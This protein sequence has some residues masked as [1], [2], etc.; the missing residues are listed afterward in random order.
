MDESGFKQLLSAIQA[1]LRAGRFPDA[2]S[3][4]RRAIALR[5]E[6]GA[7]CMNLAAALGAQGKLVEALDWNER[8]IR[9]RPTDPGARFNH[10]KTLFDLGRF[11][12]AS[13][14][15]E[16]SLRLS[17]GNR[18]AMR[19]LGVCRHLTHRDAEAVEI[20][21][22]VVA[23]GDSDPAAHAYLGQAMR[24]LGRFD[25]AFD[26]HRLAVERSP[27]DARLRH[28]LGL[29]LLLHGQWPEGWR[30]A[31]ARWETPEMQ[32]IRQKMPPLMWDG[33]SLRGK[34]IYLQP[35]QGLGD[36]IQFIRYAERI[37][38]RGGRVVAGCDPAL[39]DL[40]S[41]VPGVSEAVHIVDRPPVCDCWIGLMSLPFVFDTQPETA[42]A[43]VPY[44]FPEPARVAKWS[45]RIGD[46]TQLRVGIAWAGSPKHLRDFYRS[47]TLEAI[48]PLAEIANL[49][50]FSLQKDQSCAGTNLTDLATD[51][52]TL[53]DTAAAIANLDLVISVDTAV[54]HLAGAMGKPVWLLLGYSPDWRWM[55]DRPDSPWYP[56][57]RI[58]RQSKLNDW[59]E[60][61]DRIA[62]ELQSLSC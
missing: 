46:A 12:D 53:A 45:E 9:L 4:L 5:G 50:A 34:L 36:T 30:L 62:G 19:E 51:L 43:N 33:A 39:R 44:V 27:D 2:E 49:R 42:P 16:T 55:L 37:A 32:R 59:E 14:A 11:G 54:A 61:I 57:M 38:E 24:E 3:G 22:R 8:A 26:Q 58:F 18:M 56:T 29:N 41:T 35:E 28:V 7:L 47:T 23:T 1:N 13:D 31:E 10:G 52:H 25:E 21:T 60:L 15:F 17:P 48:T 20:L 6:D 40:I